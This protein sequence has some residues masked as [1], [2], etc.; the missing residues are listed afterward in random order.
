MS[1]MISTVS[2]F[3]TVM[4]SAKVGGQFVTVYGS[5]EKALN[6]GRGAN[7]I[8]P[9][10]KPIRTFHAQFHFGE[11]YDKKVAKMM[12]QGQEVPEYDAA[13]RANITHLVPNVVMQYLSTGTTCLIVM[14]TSWTEDSLTLNGRPLTQDE[15][16][17][18]QKYLK[19]SSPSK[20]PYKTLGLKNIT[21]IT[22]GKETYEVNIRD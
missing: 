17:Y 20:L 8:D 10:F 2:E 3:V 21:K 5:K 11:D 19:K 1:K 18:M 13:K 22:M 7:A 15:I 4:E 9:N 12:A 14:P 6:K 16:T